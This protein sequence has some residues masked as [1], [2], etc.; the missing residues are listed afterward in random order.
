[1]NDNLQH[2]GQ[3]R[4]LVEGI[5]NKGIIDKSVLNALLK[6]P[7]HFFLESAFEHMAYEDKALPIG[8]GQTISQPYTVAFQ[9]Q[10]LAIN[11]GDKI[12]EIGTGSGYQTCVLLELGAKVYTIERKKEL[13]IKAQ[14]LLSKMGYKANFFYGDGYDG[15]PTYGPFDKI[16]ITAGATEIPPKLLSQI[17]LNGIL[18]APIGSPSVQIMNKLV[19]VSENK[20]QSSTHNSFVFVPLLP[21]KD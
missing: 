6:I 10:L 11:K 8:E 19:K 16:L 5:I 13:Y 1:M 7:R 17:K 12:L 20:F 9:S 21:G 4:I 2:K 14:Q 15:L 18:V 3:R